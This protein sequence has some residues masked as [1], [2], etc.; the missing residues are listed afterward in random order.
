MKADLASAQVEREK[1]KAS[2]VE[3]VV[4]VR[5]KSVGTSFDDVALRNG[6]HLQQASIQKVSD[7]S[8][9]FSHSGGVLRVTIDDLPDFLKDKFRMGIF[10]MESLT[11]SKGPPI[12]DAPTGA[13]PT[14]APTPGIGAAPTSTVNKEHIKIDIES[15]I[16]KMRTVELNKQGWIDRAKELREQVSALQQAGKPSY[17]VNAEAKQADINAAA[18]AAQLNQIQEQLIILRKKLADIP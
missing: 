14:S 8:I 3:A 17:T 5:S 11:L 6:Q 12:P 15:L 10:P 2:F 13:M 7:G 4:N 9:Q 18:T 1:L 16:E